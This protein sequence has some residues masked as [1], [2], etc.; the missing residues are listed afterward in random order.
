MR[1]T[2]RGAARQLLVGLIEMVEIEMHV[3]EGV[4]ELAR[5]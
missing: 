3:A 1:G 2:A 4:D 5:A